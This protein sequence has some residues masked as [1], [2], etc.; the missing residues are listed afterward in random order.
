MSDN[1][2]FMTLRATSVV[3]PKEECS[4]LPESNAIMVSPDSTEF[5]V[6]MVNAK[7]LEIVDD[8]KAVSPVL[9]AAIEC[10]MYDLIRIQEA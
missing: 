6:D 8:L 7:S 10:D 9:K 2:V 1:F 3:L 4:E 5:T